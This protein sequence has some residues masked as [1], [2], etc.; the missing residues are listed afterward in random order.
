[1]GLHLLMC[2]RGVLAGMVKPQ[3]AELATPQVSRLTAAVVRTGLTIHPS[4]VKVAQA[5]HACRK[6][7]NKHAA[8]QFQQPSHGSAEAVHTT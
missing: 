3:K 2:L 8:D 4:H 7:V 1:M 5:V 6:P